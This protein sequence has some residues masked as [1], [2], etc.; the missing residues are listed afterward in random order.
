MKKVVIIYRTLF[1]YRKE[2]YNQLRDSL[3]E[4]NVQ[5][6]IIYGKLNS[7]D[8]ESRKDQIDLEWGQFIQNKVLHLGKKELIWQP[9]LK[10]LKDKDMV[11]VE[12]ANKLLINYYLMFTRQ[13]LGLKF[14]YWGHG[15]NL[16]MNENN[17]YNK[18]KYLF[19]KNCD[20]WF[21]YTQGVK[22]FLVEMGFPADK[23][24][25]V[26]NA[27][28]TKNLLMIYNQIEDNEI[29]QLKKDNGIGEG[30]I[31]LYC[32]GM[33][34]E[35]RLDFLLEACTR[36]KLEIPSFEMIFIGAGPDDFKI[37][38]ASNELKWIHYLGPKFNNDKVPFFKM[39]C[40][41]LMPGLVGLAIL[42]TFSMQTPI[43]TTKYPFHSP[44]IEYLENGFN[45]IMT[46]NNLE[47]Y[48]TEIIK[49]LNDKT[50][51]NSLKEGCQQS[52]TKY[53]TEKMVS[54]F[55]EGIKKCLNT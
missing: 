45:G 15:R 41:F 1:Q 35:K 27:I 9:C 26:Q 14:C 40:L 38:K 19:I 21:A 47:A 5:L 30:P 29:K 24:S 37:K 55:V 50:K 31:G 22:G 54:N 39:S 48:T 2:F 17:I 25:P 33:Y 43:I 53:T 34:E 52:S 20:W 46:D 42:D 4:N 18:F 32:G 13:R 49:V 10:D 3:L 8:Y 7:T 11:I 23:I 16:Q 6:Y 28:N 36:I 12:Q 44:E 51:L